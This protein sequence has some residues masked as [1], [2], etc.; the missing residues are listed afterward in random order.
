MNPLYALEL[1]TRTIAELLVLA[2]Q[3]ETL[4]ADNDESQEERANT[5][6]N[7]EL[8]RREIQNRERAR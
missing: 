2:K 8:V 3:I 1:E 4:I 6:V 7:R 5:F